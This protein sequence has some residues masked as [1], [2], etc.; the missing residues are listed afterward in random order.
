MRKR[1]GWLFLTAVLL[2]A[3]SAVWAQ[4]HGGDVPPVIFTGPLS[5]P[6]FEEGGFYCFLQGLYWRETRPVRNQVIAV[7][8]LIDLDGSISGVSPGAF[9]GSGVDAL[10]TQQLRGPGSYQ[11]GFNLG[12]G[13]RFEGGVVVQMN[14]YHLVDAQYSATAGLLPSNFRTRDD[15]ADSYL[16]A[17]V[18]NFPIE[19]SG[20]PL[21]T[22]TGNPG[23]TFG[24]WNAAS[25][26]SLEFLQRFDMFELSGRIP[27]WQTENFRNYGLVGPRAVVMWERFRW[28]TVDMD[29]FGSATADTTANYTNITSN[30]LYGIHAGCGYEWYLGDTPIGAFSCTLDLEGSIYGDFVKG[31]ASYELGD[32]STAA[33]R[34]R[35]MAS[36]VPGVEGRLSLWWYPWEAIQ[37]QVGYNAMVFFNTVASPRPVDFDFGSLDPQ[38]EHG[39][40]RFFH[41]FTFGIGFVF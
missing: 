11:P 30:R 27:I 1:I 32:R 39:I 31:R 8:G 9:I 2:G 13:W 41:G 3:P 17:K 19:Y 12:L 22:F 16:T 37:V 24:I 23:A 21:N 5:H 4:Q 36:I 38:W 25:N 40:T 7:R 10:S 15:L 29:Q 28:R 6:R 26:M 20:N 18:F 14:W 34:S 33:K 35:N